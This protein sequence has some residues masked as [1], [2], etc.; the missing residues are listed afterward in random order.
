MEQL[1]QPMNTN[2]YINPRRLQYLMMLYGVSSADILTKLNEKRK[3]KLE[4]GDISEKS[5]K[6]SLLKK[7]DKAFFEKGLSFYTDPSPPPK[8]R[9]ASIFFRKNDFNSKMTLAD[10]WRINKVEAELANLRAIMKLSGFEMTRKLK[11]YKTEDNPR[12]VANEI[13]RHID[14]KNSQHLEDDRDFLKFMIEEFSAL[15]ILVYEFVEVH[16]LRKKTSWEGMFLEPDAIIVKRNQGA[17]KREIFTLVHEL[18]HYL[19]NSEEVDD[20]PYKIRD[21]AEQKGIEQWCNNFA[22]YFIVGELYKDIPMLFKKAPNINNADIRDISRKTRISRL[23]IYTNLVMTRSIS[24][25]K[26]KQLVECLRQEYKEERV[27]EREIRELSGEEI[28]GSIPKPIFSSLE[29]DVYRH[30][31]FAGTVE[32]IDIINRFKPTSVQ[33]EKGFVDKLLYGGL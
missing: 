17:F 28:E 12:A 2:I 21:T 8:S 7:I 1:V 6:L 22:Y 20:A 5:I 9:S 3:K 4:A 27:R 26:Y 30:A 10:R 31:Y 24:W 19:L 18:G 23:A 14:L 16:N 29:E 15:N 13:R 33:R 32:E 25:D 11:R